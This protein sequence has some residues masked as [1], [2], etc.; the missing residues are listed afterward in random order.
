VGRAV[1]RIVAA[2]QD[3][4]RW[5]NDQLGLR[6]LDR[7]RGIWSWKESVLRSESADIRHLSSLKRVA[8]DEHRSL[9]GRMTGFYCS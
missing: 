4:E 1:S 8:N 6:L 7:L 5:N 9:A 2:E 3:A